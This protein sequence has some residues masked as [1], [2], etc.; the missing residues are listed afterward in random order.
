MKDNLRGIIP[1][2]VTPF[3]PDEDLDED[4]LRREMQYFL[5]TGVHGIGFGGSTGE[6]AVLS[7]PELARGIQILQEENANGIP[8][9]CGVIRNSTRDAIS[10][11]LAAKAA[12]ADAL[13]L[14]PTFYHGTTEAG[15][16]EFFTA[17]AAKVQLPI[18]IYNVIKNNPVSPPAMERLAEIDG[19][20]G[21]KQSLGGIHALTDMIAACGDKAL[22]FAAQ[23]DLMFASFLL[24]AAG[25]IAAILSLFPALFVEQWNALHA[26]NLERARQ[27]HYQVLPIWRKIEGDAFPGKIK[28]AINLTGRRVGKARSPIL[29]PSALE[30]E[31]LRQE[32]AKSGLL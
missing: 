29:E 10:A 1:P 31:Q 9:L 4:A 15:N 11:G 24:G 28:A 18:L 5:A 25:A 19:I 26:G 20:V 14:T 12:G 22:V 7:D 2:L 16:H 3:T 17:V 8:I 21:I 32:M 30:L 13:L 6:G 27:I 23:D